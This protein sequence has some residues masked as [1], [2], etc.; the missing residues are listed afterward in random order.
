[1]EYI[2]SMVRCIVYW[3]G[4]C[5]IVRVYLCVC[6][7]SDFREPVAYELG[8]NVLDDSIPTEQIENGC[9]VVLES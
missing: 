3:V 1:M 8:Y 9:G 4:A 2:K 5:A 6:V 7:C